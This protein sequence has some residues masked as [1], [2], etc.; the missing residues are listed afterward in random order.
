MGR[1][2]RSNAR[3]LQPLTGRGASHTAPSEQRAIENG[4]DIGLA[5]FLYLAVAATI[6]AFCFW[7]PDFPKRLAPRLGIRGETGIR[8]FLLVYWIAVPV[9]IYR[10]LYL[11]AAA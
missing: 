3:E 2:C 6:I 9:V 4:M 7:Q 1:R 10:F 8:R 5:S 11:A